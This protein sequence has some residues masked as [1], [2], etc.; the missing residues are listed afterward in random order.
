MMPPLLSLSWKSLVNRR[1]TALLTV[2]A[3]AL[4]VAMLLMVE[5]VRNDARQS[6]ANTISGTDLIVGARSGSIQLLLYSVFH[7]GN[8]TNNISWESYQEIAGRP[9]VDWAVPISLGDSHR[10]FR[11]MGTSRAYFEHYRFARDRGLEFETGEPFRG[12]FDAVLGAE[13]ARSLG[14]RVGDEIV[15]AHGAG[16]V[17]FVQHD[18][19]PFTITGILQRTGT[20]VDRTVVVGLEG[21]EAIHVGWEGGTPPPRVVSTREVMRLDLVPDEITAFLLGLKS[22]IDVFRLQRA[23][24]E[25]R[26]EPLLAIIPGVALQQLW[27]LMGVAERALLIIS[28]FVIAIGLVGMLAMILSSLNE[29]RREMAILRSV[30]ARPAH[31]FGLLLSEALLLAAAG[32]VL[33]VALLYLLLFFGQPVVEDRFGLLLSIDMLS[34]RELLML[35]GV[36]AGAVIMGVAPAYRAYRLSLTDGLSMKV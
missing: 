19:K 36:L 23:V 29:R 13:V 1:F 14:Y 35:N 7:I 2:C 20:P 30:G 22:R 9:Q 4:S 12:I 6:F 16:S 25:Y 26:Q 3:I 10:G 31:V 11:V 21:V 18:D 33:G 28:G 24:N 5:R 34:P 8:A 32:I 15:I 17:S 27:D